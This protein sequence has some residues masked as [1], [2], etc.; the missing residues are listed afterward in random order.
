MA[1]Q[2]LCYF[3]CP[4]RQRRSEV[5]LLDSRQRNDGPSLDDP[6]VR[7]PVN[8]LV[9]ED[10]TTLQV[11]R[12]DVDRAEQQTPQWRP[13]ELVER[14]LDDI[15]DIWAGASVVASTPTGYLVRY[16]DDGSL[17]HDVDGQELRPRQ[18]CLDLPVDVWISIGTCMDTAED[19]CSFEVITLASC[20]AMRRHSQTWWCCAYHHR[21]GRCGPRC[22]FE[23]V[24]SMEARR[25]MSVAIQKCLLTAAEGLTTMD[26]KPWKDR[27]VEQEKLF[28]SQQRVAPSLGPSDAAAYGAYTVSGQRI[29]QKTPHAGF[30][31]DGRLG[32]MVRDQ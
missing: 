22:T 15:S 2:R 30:F 11:Q 9:L 13:G 18:A 4:K 10:A 28:R 8:S 17:E 16:D 19:L 32:R 1:F 20:Q 26:R 31:Y 29:G 3:C 6:V 5:Y 25:A 21:F 27:F 12:E 23:K 14:L 7:S 24:V